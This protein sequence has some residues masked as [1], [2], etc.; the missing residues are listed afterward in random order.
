[1]RQVFQHL[2]NAQV[3]HALSKLHGYER[4]LVTEHH[5]S[6]GP[7]VRP[8]LDKVHGFDTRLDRRSGIYLDAAP[9]SIPKKELELVLELPF[10]DFES[11]RD[12]GVLR[13]YEWTPAS[14]G[15]SA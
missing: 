7:K 5:P 1:V 4:V 15:A 8:N 6:D 9:F 10:S 2:S 13:T 12:Q 11:G 3:A 14:A